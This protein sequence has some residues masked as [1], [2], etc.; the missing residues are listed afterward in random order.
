MHY[1]KLK[2][3]YFINKLNLKNL[4]KLNKNVSVIYRKYTGNIDEKEIIKI[5]NICKKVGR[6]FFISN[7][8][9]LALKLSLDGVYLPAFNKSLKHNVYGIRKD[10]KIIGSAHNI[11]EIKEKEAQ[12][13]KIIFIASLFKVKKTFLGINKF[14]FL[15]NQTNSKIV[16][17]GGI[18][19]EN[20]KKLNLVKIIGFAGISYFE[21]KK[22][23]P[24]RGR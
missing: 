10:F 21:Q 4:N 16:A 19:H 22:T 24:K 8:V 6:K 23:A 14:N 1:I 20:I 11:K 5:K 2:N 18:S 13:V 17:L 12:G 9:K 15:S 7:N 3:F